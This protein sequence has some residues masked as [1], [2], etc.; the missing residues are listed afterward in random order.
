MTIK[1]KTKDIEI[2]YQDEYSIIEE[3]AK[4]RI[5][6]LLDTVF[7]KQFRLETSKPIILNQDLRPIKCK[8]CGGEDKGQ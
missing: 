1:I 4:I 5:L 2:E 7:E 8:Y 3:A 6:A